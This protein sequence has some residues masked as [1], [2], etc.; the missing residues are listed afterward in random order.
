MSK[1][2]HFQET[3]IKDKKTK[4]MANAI[5]EME[6][7]LRDRFVIFSSALINIIN[8]YH[9][10]HKDDEEEEFDALV[11]GKEKAKK[12]ERFALR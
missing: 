10:D 3:L 6:K 1:V 11:S 8:L 7:Y 5:E 9:R 4:Q 2:N 12:L